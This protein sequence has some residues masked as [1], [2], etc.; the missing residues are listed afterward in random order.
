M[1]MC[2]RDSYNISNV[3]REGEGYLPID[4]NFIPYTG[5]TRNCYSVVGY[6]D[7]LCVGIGY[8]IENVLPV[9]HASAAMDN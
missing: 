7:V 6:G 5:Q 4:N 1:E 9:E 3:K 2:I 8:T